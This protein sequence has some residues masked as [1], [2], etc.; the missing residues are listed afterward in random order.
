MEIYKKYVKRPLKTYSI[1]LAYR[2]NKINLC[3]I[4]KLT[5]N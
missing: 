1:L 3:E 5:L 4:R 2:L